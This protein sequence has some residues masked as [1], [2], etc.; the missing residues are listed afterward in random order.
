MSWEGV[1]RSSWPLVTPQ[2]QHLL[3]SALMAAR[4]HLLQEEQEQ[5]A[6]DTA[7]LHSS[8]H[9]QHLTASLSRSISSSITATSLHRCHSLLATSTTCL[10]RSSLATSSLAMVEEQAGQALGPE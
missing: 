4:A 3:L 7:F 8:L 10:A 5:Q 1:M 6:R 9:L 2:P